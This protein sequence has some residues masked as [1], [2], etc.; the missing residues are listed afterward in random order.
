[1]SILNKLGNRTKMLASNPKVRK[2][3]AVAAGV[4]GVAAAGYGAYRLL[5]GGKKKKSTTT[6]L[7]GQV[8]RLALKIRKTQLEKKLFKEQMKVQY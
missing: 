7:K 1:M 8:Q 2:G 3:L 4:A 6:K 5:R